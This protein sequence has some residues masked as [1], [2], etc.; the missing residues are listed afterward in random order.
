[1]GENSQTLA[2]ALAIEGK[3]EECVSNL[4]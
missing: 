1:M 2:R 4:S 3:G